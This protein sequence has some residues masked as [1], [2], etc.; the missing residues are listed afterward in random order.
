M[1]RAKRAQRRLDFDNMEV[2]ATLEAVLRDAVQEEGVDEAVCK[3]LP[4]Y[5]IVQRELDKMNAAVRPKLATMGFLCWVS[6]FSHSVGN[7]QQC[8]HLAVHGHLATQWHQTCPHPSP[9]TSCCTGC[10]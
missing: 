4:R 7:W 2:I 6:C 9:W 10:C 8:R 5:L 3:E 1:D